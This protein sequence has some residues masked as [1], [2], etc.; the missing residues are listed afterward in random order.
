LYCRDSSAVKQ[1]PETSIRVIAREHNLSYSTVQINLQEE[2]MHAY[3]CVQNLQE[4]DYPRRRKF[5]EN[6]LRKVDEDPEFPS[7]MILSNES[8]FTRKGIV[9]SHNMRM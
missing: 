1:E 8:L 6:F 4:K 5:C 2:K 3:T 9:N 7:R